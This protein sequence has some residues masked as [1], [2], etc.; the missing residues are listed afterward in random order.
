VAQGIAPRPT[1]HRVH[2][3][4]PQAQSPSHGTMAFGAAHSQE[5]IAPHQVL[6]WTNRFNQL[7]SLSRSTSS[8]ARFLEGILSGHMEPVP[9]HLRT[10]YRV[11][12]AANWYR[13]QLEGAVSSWG[14]RNACAGKL[15][16]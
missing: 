9:L 4:E 1:V 3:T 16:P 2:T 8:G 7:E 15:A 12:S 5:R 10:R 11:Y 13:F 6:V 14:A